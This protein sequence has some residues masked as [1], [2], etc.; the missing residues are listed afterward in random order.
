VAELLTD[1]EVAEYLRVSLATVRRW[2][3]E[4]TGPPWFRAGRSVRY[5]RRALDEWI[6]RQERE[7]ERGE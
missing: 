4:G 6:K 7:R 5:S 2:R 1:V 3:S